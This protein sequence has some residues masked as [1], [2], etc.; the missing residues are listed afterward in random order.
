MR[1]SEKTLARAQAAI[2]KSIESRE[3]RVPPLS[4][5]SRC[6]GAPVWH[7]CVPLLP[8]CPVGDGRLDWVKTLL[9]YYFESSELFKK[10]SHLTDV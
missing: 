4:M 7:S 6:P 3:R 9:G 10:R 2:L 8:R 1:A 5:M